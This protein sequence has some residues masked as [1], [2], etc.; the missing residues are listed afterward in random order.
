MAKNHLKRIHQMT[1][2]DWEKAFPDEHSCAA[3]LVRHRWPSGTVR[4]PRCGSVLVKPHGTM[5][6]NWLCNACS[7]SGTNYRFS[8]IAGTIFENTNKPLRDWFRVI[9]LMLTSKKGISALQIHRMMGFGSYKT[10]WYMCHRVRAG[11]ANE[12]FR[13]L[14]GLVE[15][16]E[17]YVGGKDKNRHAD[18]R[19][20]AYGGKKDSLKFAVIGAVERKGNVVARVLDKV[21]SATMQS[22]VHE[23]VAT[24]VS[25]LTTDDALGYRGLKD[26]HPMHGTVD[27]GRRQY[28][29][30]ALHT[31]TI[32]G[33]WSLI[34]R[35]V[36]GSYHKVSRKYLPL[37]VAEF[38]FRYNNRTN[39]DIFGEAIRGC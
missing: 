5:E 26:T 34:K 20:H 12:E 18:R 38:Q 27:H 33:F 16:D 28:V 36:M 17:T 9:H 21:N 39:P 15:V 24:D 32:E 7:P 14:I 1:F 29:T 11:L 35:G 23:V 6:F 2:A 22:F 37:Y 8:V 13:K 19:Q 3:Y 25:L 4:C 10:A 31:N 30:G